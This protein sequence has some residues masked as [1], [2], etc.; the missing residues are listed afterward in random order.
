MS[1]V[2]GKHFGNQKISL[3]P[4]FGLNSLMGDGVH[5]IYRSGDRDAAPQ[6]LQLSALAGWGEGAAE[7]RFVPFIPVPPLP[8]Q[9]RAF[10][11]LCFIPSL[12]LPF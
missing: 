3:K 12:P 11:K 7:H 5:S 4:Q 10:S 1:T 2:L 8:F 6:G 9:A